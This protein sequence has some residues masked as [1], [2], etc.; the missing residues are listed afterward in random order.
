MRP[1]NSATR[2][3]CPADSCVLCE[4][5]REELRPGEWSVMKIVG[6]CAIR[7][8]V[9]GRH[10]PRQAETFVGEKPMNQKSLFLSGL[11]GPQ[12]TTRFVCWTSK[13]T[14]WPNAKHA[15][16]NRIAAVAGLDAPTNCGVSRSGGVCYRDASR[17]HDRYASGAQLSRLP[18]QS[19]TI[20]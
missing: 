12:R 1:G 7:A 18:Y 17:G 14:R 4:R 11:V 3:E 6:S 10:L 9:Q 2:P 13:A 8:P 19:E 5:L 20:G 16:Q 15:E